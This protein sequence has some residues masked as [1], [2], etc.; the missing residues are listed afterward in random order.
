M[1][2][3]LKLENRQIHNN[4]DLMEDQ[5]D[6]HLAAMSEGVGYAQR[7]RGL[8][9][10]CTCVL[11]SGCMQENT[12]TTP[13]PLSSSAFWASTLYN[14]TGSFCSSFLIRKVLH[15]GEGRDLQYLTEAAQ[16]SA[17]C[18][19]YVPRRSLDNRQKLK[20]G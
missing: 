12:T 5:M 1:Y 3:N 13:H 20:K 11:G 7:K 16:W 8:H 2:A 10:D 18:S 14:L 19:Y 4:Q 9:G 17:Q 6:K 15:S